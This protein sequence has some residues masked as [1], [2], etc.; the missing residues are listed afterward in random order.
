MILMEIVRGTRHLRDRSLLLQYRRSD[1]SRIELILTLL[2]FARAS[3]TE[4][5]SLDVLRALVPAPGLSAL[6]LRG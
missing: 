3:E 5:I 2:G 4:E 6:P 1:A